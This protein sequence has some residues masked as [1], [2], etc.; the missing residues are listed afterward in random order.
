MQIS[1]GLLMVATV[2]SANYSPNPLL[3]APRAKI[4]PPGVSPAACPNY[5]DCSTDGLNFATGIRYA[6]IPKV[7]T[8]PAGIPPA[9]CVNYPFCNQS[10]SQ[11]YVQTGR[12]DLPAGVPAAACYNYPYC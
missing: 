8:W 9:S 2:A 3:Q 11:Q 4:W 12:V 10:P 7:K 6:D 5:P 1:L